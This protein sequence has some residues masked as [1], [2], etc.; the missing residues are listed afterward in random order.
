MIV[1]A[2][3]SICIYSKNGLNLMQVFCNPNFNRFAQILKACCAYFASKFFASKLLNIKFIFSS[4][5]R[6]IQTT[7]WIKFN[8]ILWLKY[9]LIFSQA[10][11]EIIRLLYVKIRKYKISYFFNTYEFIKKNG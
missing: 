7:Y 4:T 8:T 9:F 3:S 5:S 2:L 10:I 6:L 11:S 1:F